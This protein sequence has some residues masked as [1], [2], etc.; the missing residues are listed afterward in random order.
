MH[1][2][3]HASYPVLYR[4]LM[5]VGL[6]GAVYRLQPEAMLVQAAVELTLPLPDPLRRYRA[7]AAR[8]AIQL[9]GSQAV[10]GSPA[11]HQ[12]RGFAARQLVIALHAGSHCFGLSTDLGLRPGGGEPLH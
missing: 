9:A 8:V 11:Q 12:T 1:A 10:V 3:F 7:L 2:G 4:Q 5:I 6:L